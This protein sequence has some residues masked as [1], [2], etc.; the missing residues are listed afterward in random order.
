MYFLKNHKTFPV[1][2]YKYK[3][4]NR[5]STDC[6]KKIYSLLNKNNSLGDS[7]MFFQRQEEKSFEHE[8]KHVEKLLKT[9][10]Y[11]NDEKYI[12]DI[13]E[14]LI[15]KPKMEILEYNGEKFMVKDYKIYS[16]SNN[17][18]K[19]INILKTFEESAHV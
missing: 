12:E 16:L 4:F 9:I 7:G 8:H 17:N 18:S 19:W 10:A 14:Y 13:I 11:Y 6:L 5:L 15:Y 3:K 1:C 2:V